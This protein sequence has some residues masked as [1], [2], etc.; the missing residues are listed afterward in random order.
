MVSAGV[1][2]L[3]CLL[4]L[5]PHGWCQLVSMFCYVYLVYSPMDG[6]SWCQCFVMFTWST[7]PWMVSAGVNVLLCL[8]GLQP[9]GWCQ[10]VSMVCCVPLAYSPMD[11]VS[12]CQCFVM[13][14]W[15]TAPWM[16][17]AGVNVLLCLLGLQPHG[18]CQLVSMVCCVPL[19]YS[20][21]DGVSWCQCFVVFPWPT[22]PWMVSAGVNVLLCSL[23][24]QPHGWCQLVSM[25]YRTQ[26]IFSLTLVFK[27]H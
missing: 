11:G 19:A 10:L 5:Q 25:H 1:N 23:G 12:W 3:L 18:W 26:T 16:V 9:H 15:S 14:T 4:G 13:F 6:V 24:L 7:A 17:S 8:L 2:G 21:M 20:P 27:L 22:A